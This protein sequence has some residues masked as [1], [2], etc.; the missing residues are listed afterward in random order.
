MVGD[1]TLD[2]QAG[3]TVGMVTI[4]VLTGRIKRW[5]F[6]RAGAD[7]VLED[8]TQVCRLLGI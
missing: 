6:E 2:I 4:G 5:E 7:A 8:A 3:K 1:H